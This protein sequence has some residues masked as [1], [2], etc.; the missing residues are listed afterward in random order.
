M[1][2]I[3]LLL[4][5]Y[6]LLSNFLTYFLPFLPFYHFILNFYFSFSFY[7]GKKK[8][9]LKIFYFAFFYVFTSLPFYF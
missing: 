8:R 9:T 3:F 1:S 2:F 4:I 7:F 5:F 6:G